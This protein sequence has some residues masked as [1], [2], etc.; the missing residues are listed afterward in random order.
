MVRKSTLRALVKNLHLKYRFHEVSALQN[1]IVS[2]QL[3][4]YFLELFAQ[5]EESTKLFRL[6][7]RSFRIKIFFFE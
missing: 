4:V 1:L 6:L 3:P 7:G 2:V 5:E